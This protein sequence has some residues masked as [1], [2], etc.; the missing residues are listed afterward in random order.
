MFAYTKFVTVACF[1]VFM[2]LQSMA[3]PHMGNKHSRDR[4]R[5]HTKEHTREHTRE[6]ESTEV[7]ST[8]ISTDR[9]SVYGEVYETRGADSYK[10]E[11]RQGAPMV[12]A[13]CG[14]IEYMCMPGA[15]NLFLQ[16]SGGVYIMKECGSGTFCKSSGVGLRQFYGNN[17]NISLCKKNSA[18]SP[19]S[20]SLS[21]SPQMSDTDPEAFTVSSWASLARSNSHT[22]DNTWAW[23]DLAPNPE[24][25]SQKDHCTPPPKQKSSHNTPAKHRTSKLNTPSLS[26]LNNT[27]NLQNQTLLNNNMHPTSVENKDSPSEPLIYPTTVPHPYLH[28]HS[29]DSNPYTHLSIFDRMFNN[30][31]ILFPQTNSLPTKASPINNM[32]EPPHQQLIRKP[33]SSTSFDELASVLS[34]TSSKHRL[35]NSFKQPT[36]T[37]DTDTP[38]RG[39]P[40]H[41][42]QSSSNLGIDINNKEKWKPHKKDDL[43]ANWLKRG[44]LSSHTVRRASLP[45]KNTSKLEKEKHSPTN[46]NIRNNSLDKLPAVRYKADEN[47]FV[48]IEM[49]PKDTTEDQTF[50]SKTNLVLERHSPKP[51][52]TTK[53]PFNNQKSSIKNK[54]SS[55]NTE[56]NNIPSLPASQNEESSNV[57]NETKDIFSKPTRWMSGDISFGL[58]M[59]KES[60]LTE[61][62]SQTTYE[63][64]L[65]E[66]LDFQSMD[67]SRPL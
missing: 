26:N 66:F 10:H 52:F 25:I 23:S 64:A 38:S 62:Q 44:V 20:L 19:K 7:Q 50:K 43:V 29:S 55:N 59:W 27:I 42:P 35:S 61:E 37:S 67:F 39:K 32:F 17:K 6:Q 11:K 40:K 45:T 1:L 16:C 30:T 56:N 51:E 5:K 46:S 53:K 8:P 63:K 36:H 12:G 18:S 41:K 21:L 58:D 31:E 9:Y 22:S 4:S 13:Q 34:S 47:G 57:K 54:D 24:P 48:K 2:I 14:G 28:T 65:F 33:S 3:A 15:P 60:I 49:L